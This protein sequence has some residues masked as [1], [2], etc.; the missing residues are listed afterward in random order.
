MAKLK[1]G[2]LGERAI[3]LPPT[4]IEE[5]KKD[6]LGSLLYITDIGYYPKANYHFR[7]RT[8]DEANQFVLIYCIAG[9]GWFEIEGIKQ[10]VNPEHF[11]I[12]P[13]GK[14]HSYGCNTKDP[15]TIYW[16]HFDGE[17]AGFF[18]E[19]LDTPIHIAIQKDSRI[20]ERLHLFEEIFT[21]LKNGYSKN[22]LDY[23]TAILFH[24]LGSL[25]FL[26]A[27]R[28]NFLANQ[29]QTDMI[30]ETI[31]FMREHLYQK[32]SLKEIADYVGLSVSHFASVFQKKTGYAPLNYFSQ[33]KI[34]QAC[35]F[36]DFSDMKIS[37]I[38]MTIGFSDP[39]Y[40]S[41]VFSKTMGISPTEY[42]NK[43]KG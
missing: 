14:A 25:K 2:F 31:H 33:L 13:K 17:K 42:R 4:I 20:E 15:W 30:T 29:N 43:K 22:N 41:R 38:S 10:K 24:F 39:L 19:G 27:Y 5:L 11:F 35:Q 6:T 18:S 3:I 37:Q 16:L 40:F 26:G 34:Q 36:L 1:N 8:Q 9:S 23:S 28:D 32:I 21:T 7:K 12:L